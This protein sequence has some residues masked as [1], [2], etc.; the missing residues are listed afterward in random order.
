MHLSRLRV[1]HLRNLTEATLQPGTRFNLIV[2]ANASGKTSLLEAI[3]LLGLGT[4]FR[5]HQ[6]SNV[7]QYDAASAVV[8][9]VVE[10]GR[11]G[12]ISLGVARHRNGS[13]QMRVQGKDVEK[14][15][16]LTRQ[17]PIMVLGADAHSL[18]EGGPRERRRYV[19][20]GVFHVEH[21]YLSQWRSVQRL[22]DQ[23]NR[24]LKQGC[25]ER[26]LDVWDR[27]LAESG[28]ALTGTRLAY[29][30]KLLA[31]LDSI[32]AV[33]ALEGLD[34]AVGFF[35]G[36]KKDQS[37]LE[38]LRHSRASD[39]SHGFTGSGPHRAELRLRVGKHPASEILSRGQQKHLAY[40]LRLAQ[41]VLLAAET[42]RSPVVLV[43]DLGAELDEARQESVLMELEELGSQVFVTSLDES[44]RTRMSPTSVEPA[45]FHVEHG[46][47][48]RVI[49]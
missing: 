42:G 19:D 9:G 6:I 34:V 21:G 23:R 31:I 15:A 38:M 41:G 35:R 24:A 48:R 47:V 49:Y 45:V 32:K 7:I 27:Q 13:L 29:L 14:R 18:V 39:R 17:L 36:W 10:D 30:E 12:S 16:E 3:H 40:A 25:S 33:L 20:W 22:L 5:T 4:S 28:E 46:Q 37:L 11:G 2:G 44:V 1:R 43:D 8:H 26:E